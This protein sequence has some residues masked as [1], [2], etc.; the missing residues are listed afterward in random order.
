MFQAEYFVDKSSNTLADSL[1]AFGLAFVLNAVANPEGPR[2]A[3][4]RLED[5]GY[6]FVVVCNPPLRPEWVEECEFFVGTPFLVTWDKKSAR[7]VV[8]GTPLTPAELEGRGS[9]TVVDYEVE[10]QKNQA[11]FEWLRG[12]STE[13]KRR[14]VQGELQGPDSPRADW[15]VF[16]A[17]NPGALQ[18]YNSLMAAWWQ[19]RAA[20]DGSL[21]FG[22]AVGRQMSRA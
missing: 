2:R 10:K 22:K 8:K 21:I 17:I 9:E 3:V 6:A 1:A 16:R 14:A 7:K 11:Y 5:H 4:I 13:D 19:G 12:L 18:A 15:E 20:F